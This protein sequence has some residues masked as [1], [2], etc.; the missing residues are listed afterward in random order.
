MTQK[1]PIVRFLLAVA[2][3]VRRVLKR[4]GAPGSG[5]SYVLLKES[6]YL[7][8]TPN[9]FCLRVFEPLRPSR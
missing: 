7:K 3:F 2:I 5:P 4:L 8:L 6:A 1:T 9:R